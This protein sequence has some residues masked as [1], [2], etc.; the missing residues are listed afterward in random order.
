MPD[1]AE[2]SGWEWIAPS[3][4]RA[5]LREA[6]TAFTPWFGVVLG[7]LE[8]WLATSPAA[9]SPDALRAWRSAA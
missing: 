9:V 1:P 8:R 7:R 6:P 5:R 3:A 2:V 4:L